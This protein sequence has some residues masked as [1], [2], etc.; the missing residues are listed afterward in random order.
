M[1]PL[2]KSPGDRVS[3]VTAKLAKNGAGRP[4]TVKTLSSAINAMFRKTLSEPE[5]AGIVEE[6]RKKGVV[7]VNQTKVSYVLPA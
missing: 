1:K 3:L 5:I 7:V 6:L 2:P 4:G